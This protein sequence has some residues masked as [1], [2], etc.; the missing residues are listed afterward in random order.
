MST[1]IATNNTAEGF[2]DNAGRSVMNWIRAL[3]SVTPAALAASHGSASHESVA[4]YYKV[5]YRMALLRRANEVEAEA[6]AQAAELR[7][8]ARAA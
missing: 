4:S 1:A 3:L 2:L 5:G 7:K 8:L 6:P